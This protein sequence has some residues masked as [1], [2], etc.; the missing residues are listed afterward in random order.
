MESDEDIRQRRDLYAENRWSGALPLATPASKEI[1]LYLN[2]TLAANL[3]AFLVAHHTQS[4]ELS[5]NLVKAVLAAGHGRAFHVQHNGIIS[6][7]RPEEQTPRCEFTDNMRF[8]KGCGRAMT[9][10]VCGLASTIRTIYKALER[11]FFFALQQ[12][13]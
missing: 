8:R 2:H 12:T 3:V 4:E 13:Q 7:L 9:E 10:S 11:L 1:N 6:N 5:R